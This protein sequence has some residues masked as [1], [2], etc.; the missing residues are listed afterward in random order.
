M[1]FGGQASWAKMALPGGKLIALAYYLTKKVN[2]AEQL[3]YLSINIVCRH[4]NIKITRRRS[5]DGLG[6]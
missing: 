2:K 4:S 6:T 1:S 3:T 5:E